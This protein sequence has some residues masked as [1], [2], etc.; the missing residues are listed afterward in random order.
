MTSLQAYLGLLVLVAIRAVAVWN[1][2]G[3]SHPRII[4]TEL[5]DALGQK[6]G[7]RLLMSQF[8][9]QWQIAR[10]AYK[11]SFEE[12]QPR[13]DLGGLRLTSQRARTTPSP[14]LHGRCARKPEALD[15]A[16]DGVHESISV[17]AAST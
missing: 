6:R 3:H 8:L 5:G 2:A 4:S 17:T 12:L 14:L 7:Q 13:A 15:A 9:G 1:L 10:T 16:H 11:R